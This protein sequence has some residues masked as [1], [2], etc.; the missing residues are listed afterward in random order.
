M[1]A[2]T[3]LSVILL[4]TIFGIAS[5]AYFKNKEQ[6][7]RQP[8]SLQKSRMWMPA[9][10]GKHLALIKVKIESPETIP[11]AGDDEVT[12]TGRI[13]VNQDIH[14]ELSYTWAVPEDVSIIQGPLT[15]LLAA[16][17]AGEVFEVKLTVRGFNKEKQH[18]ISLNASG[19]HG[20][21][22]LGN[23]AVITSRPEDTW[24]S[25]APEMKR[26]AE[27]QLGS[28]SRPRRGQ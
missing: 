3:V 23:S 11:E 2:R 14:G 20:G 17:Q 8:S 9:P 7:S 16:S 28:S 19:I 5:G 27:E 18:L 12:L 21:E 24:E 6:L 26:A 10:V 22:R 15:G 1:R 25:V 4:G 13:L